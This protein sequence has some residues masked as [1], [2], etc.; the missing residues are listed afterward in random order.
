[1][2]GEKVRVTKRNFKLNFETGRIKPGQFGEHD[3]ATSA[4]FTVHKDAHG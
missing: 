3:G 2:E 4:N 1:M